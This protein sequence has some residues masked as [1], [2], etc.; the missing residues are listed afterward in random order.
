[1]INDISIEKLQNKTKRKR[2][3]KQTGKE[4]PRKKLMINLL[5]MKK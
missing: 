5:S 3:K 4:I 1:M 2:V